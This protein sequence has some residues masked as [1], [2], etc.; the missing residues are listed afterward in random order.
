MPDRA[1]ILVRQSVTGDR[2]ISLDAQEDACRRYCAERQYH[3][4]ALSREESTRGWRDDREA[5]AAAIRMAKAGEITVL[6]AWDVS[7]VARSVRIL[8]QLIHDIAPARLESVSEDWVASPFIRQVLAAVAE[9]QTR[10][11]GRN[12]SAAK[13][14]MAE[15]GRWQGGEAPYGYALARLPGASTVL[16]PSEPA[17]SIVQECFTRYLAGDRHWQIADSLIARGIPPPRRV[18]W[19]AH[20]VMHLLGKPVYTGASVYRGEVVREDAHPALV[21]H[22]TF[23]RVQAR[24]AESS[25]V[26]RK[27]IELSSWCEGLVYHSCGLRMYL[28]A[29][30][31][32]KLSLPPYPSFGCRSHYSQSIRACGHPRLSLAQWKLEAAVREAIAVDLEQLVPLEAAIARGIAA[33]G[34]DGTTAK[35]RELAQQRDAVERRYQRV[36]EGWLVS[37][38]GA[39]WL[40]GETERY[41]A[42]LAE[43]DSALAALPVTPDPLTYERCLATLTSVR[44]VIAHA[45]DDDLRALLLDAGTIH[46]SGPGVTI[47]W[48]PPVDAF[49]PCP[50]TVL[51]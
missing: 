13:R 17:A 34:G 47:A 42:A 28:R 44:D 26:R 6:V 23:A 29:M 9:E 45:S 2:D 21:D 24:R 31:R 10:T 50:V 36:R 37:D 43:I 46:V 51:P 19:T 20:S 11:I 48:R 30:K 49:I 15:D 16:V 39:D 32:D 4:V 40:A 25:I 7:R 33:A 27:A 8:E 35:R 3:V 18:P 22:E 12:V 1:L 14:R 38:H 41:R 5:V